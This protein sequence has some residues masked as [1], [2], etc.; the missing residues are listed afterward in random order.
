M[1]NVP[2]AARGGYELFWYGA[3][4]TTRENE[5]RATLLAADGVPRSER[6]R[7]WVEHYMAT[8]LEVNRSLNRRWGSSFV[9]KED[10]G[11]G[12]VCGRS[13]SCL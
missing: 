3:S 1:S 2:N 6:Q 9:L 10:L 11:H 13:E 8:S 5:I 4:P 12:R 7:T